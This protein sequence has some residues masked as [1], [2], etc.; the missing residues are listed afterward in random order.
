[1]F[2]H[3][4]ERTGKPDLVLRLLQC[5]KAR[6]AV[7]IEAEGSARCIETAEL[8]ETL[9]A[10]M[11]FIERWTAEGGDACPEIHPLDRGQNR[12]ALSILVGEAL[13]DW[14]QLYDATA[15]HT[16]RRTAR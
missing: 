2:A 12:Q 3:R 7:S 4:M 14:M 5:S 13:A 11:D 10:A 9:D 8:L 15:H 6:W 1:M 16:L